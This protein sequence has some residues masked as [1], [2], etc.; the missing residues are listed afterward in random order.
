MVKSVGRALVEDFGL[1]PPAPMATPVEAPAPAVEVAAPATVSAPTAG[2]IWT[3]SARRS[4]ELQHFVEHLTE[5]R[6]A[7]AAP[8]S[9]R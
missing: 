4:P 7:A 2:V 5:A 9:S 1:R 6:A 8:Q 3:G